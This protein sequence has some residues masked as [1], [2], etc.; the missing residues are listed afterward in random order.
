M[1]SEATDIRLMTEADVPRADELRRIVGWNQRPG[2]WRRILTL[3][4][5]G[6]FVATAGGELIGTVT[7][8]AYGT[9]LAWIGMMLVHPEHRRKGL[10]TQLMNRALEY[11]KGRCVK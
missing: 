8:T 1:E 4:P 5:R 10:A 3:E 9:T 6:C 11:L 2:D 7:T